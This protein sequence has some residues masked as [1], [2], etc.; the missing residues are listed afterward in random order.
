MEYFWEIKHKC[1]DHTIDNGC[2]VATIPQHLAPWQ[3]LVVQKNTAPFTHYTAQ[4]DD[5]MLGV[6]EAIMRAQTWGNNLTLGE[7]KMDNSKVHSTDRGDKIELNVG[8]CIG[9]GASISL[10][11]EAQRIKERLEEED[12]KIHDFL[13]EEDGFHVAR[14]PEDTNVKTAAA[15]NKAR[16]AAIPPI[17]IMAMGAAMQNGADKYLPF[18]WRDTEVTATVFYNAMMR[19]LLEWYSGERSASDSGIHHLAHLM[20]GAAIILDADYNGVFNDDRPNGRV[21]ADGFESF[22]ISKGTQDA[23]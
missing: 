18:N 11:R 2:R 14:K 1:G 6:V 16:T 4:D 8:S 5:E 9:D 19:H 7:L 3:Y 23:A 21:L 13:R 10:R 12:L 15:I 20:A 17:A 22:Y